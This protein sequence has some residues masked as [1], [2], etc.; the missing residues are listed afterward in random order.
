MVPHIPLNL[1]YSTTEIW[2]LKAGKRKP[3][4]IH[5]RTLPFLSFLALI[6]YHM[7]IILSSLAHPKKEPGGS[8]DETTNRLHLS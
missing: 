1:F 8:K 4:L 5:I 7:S 6:E 2:S 3:F